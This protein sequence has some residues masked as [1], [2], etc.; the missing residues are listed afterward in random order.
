V[1]AVF[2]ETMPTLRRHSA[3]TCCSVIDRTPSS[4]TLRERVVRG[5]RSNGN[6]DEEDDEEDKEEDDGEHDGEALVVERPRTWSSDHSSSSEW[7]APNSLLTAAP[8]STP[9]LPLILLLLPR[10]RAEEAERE[11][12]DIERRLGYNREKSEKKRGWDITEENRS[13]G[14]G[15]KSDEGKGNLTSTNRKRKE[16]EC[17]S[18]QSKLML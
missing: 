16:V 12:S 3:S 11:P 7:A 18:I 9:I 13:N 14:K 4:D 6:E 1:V 5:A 2:A 15:N 10:G 8:A 17:D